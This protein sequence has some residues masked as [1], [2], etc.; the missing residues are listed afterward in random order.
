MEFAQ[1]RSRRPDEIDHGSF[2]GA[3]READGG[4]ALGGERLG[5]LAGEAKMHGRKRVLE[6]ARA[7]GT[8]EIGLRAAAG[9]KPNTPQRAPPPRPP[10]PP[11]GTPRPAHPP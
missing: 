3:R 4:G 7:R 9:K 5:D 11:R 6:N 8:I 1:Q 2:V 10:N